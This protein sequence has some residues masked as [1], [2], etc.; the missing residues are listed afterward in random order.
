MTRMQIWFVKYVIA[1]AVTVAVSV[2]AIHAAHAG[3]REVNRSWT[4][5]NG[6]YSA[7]KT[8]SRSDGSWD[9]SVTRTGPNGN[10]VQR[11]RSIANNGDSVT[12]DRAVTGPQG[13]TRSV[14]RTY[15]K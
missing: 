6:T 5:P 10:S 3:S 14:T 15:S 11:D 9:R 12:V 8:V 7:S 1:T 4:G 2:A 13:N